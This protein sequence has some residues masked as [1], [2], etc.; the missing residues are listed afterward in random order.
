MPTIIILKG[1]T[2]NF[3]NSVIQNHIQSKKLKSCSHGY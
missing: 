1:F 2:S 3:L